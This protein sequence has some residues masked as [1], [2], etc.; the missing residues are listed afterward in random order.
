MCQVVASA[1]REELKQFVR[2]FVRRVRVGQDKT[3]GVELYPVWQEKAGV[4]PA[5][6]PGCV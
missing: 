3:V 5:K 4:A 6:I 2:V 1:S